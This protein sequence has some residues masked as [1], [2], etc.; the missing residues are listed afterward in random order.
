TPLSVVFPQPMAGPPP[1]P[2]PPLPPPSIVPPS[3]LMVVTPTPAAL[4]PDKP[5]VVLPPLA[6]P[7]QAEPVQRAVAIESLPPLRRAAT[8]SRPARLP[9]TGAFAER[10]EDRRRLLLPVA[11]R[12]QVA[13]DTVLLVAPGP[14][15][16]LWLTTPDH[17]DRLMDRL[18][19]S[20]AGE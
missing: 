3:G 8:L 16:C 9:L 17:L 10:L 6:P 12:E 2:P 13:P 4:P 15:A 14:T 1:P 11:L 5:L 20:R 7:Q 18:D 19:R